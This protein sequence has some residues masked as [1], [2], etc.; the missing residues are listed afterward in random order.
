M[1]GLEQQNIKFSIEHL[2]SLISGAYHSIRRKKVVS[3]SLIFIA[4]FSLFF[5][6]QILFETFFYLPGYFKIGY[7]FVAVIT[8]LAVTSIISRKVSTSTFKQFYNHF[9]QFTDNESVRNVLDLY[10]FKSDKT[11]FDHLAIDQNLRNLSPQNIESSLKDF[12]RN[13]TVQKIFNYAL[14]GILFNFFLISGFT[15]WNNNAVQRSTH[16]WKSYAKPNP[17]HYHLSPEDS[18][19]EQG[20]DFISTITFSGQKVPHQVLLAVKTSREKAFRKQKMQSITDS[21][22]VSDALIPVSNIEYYVLM[23]GYRTPVHHI[24]VQLKP[25]FESLT[26]QVSPPSYTKLDSSVYHYPFSQMNAYPG[27]IITITGITNKPVKGLFI[28]HSLKNETSHPNFFHENTRDS[29]HTSFI[30]GVTDTISFTLTDKF[31]LHNDNPFS[32]ILKSQKDQLPSVQI[33]KP[34]PEIS[35]LN[36]DSVSIN[37]ELSDDFGFHSVAL[38]YELSKA[39]VKKKTKGRLRLPV[40]NSLKADETY[41]WNLNKLNLKPLDQLTYWIEVR[42]ND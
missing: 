12:Q 35:V 6:I 21:S 38:Y 18:V 13:H 17:F 31:K 28:H 8:S 11:S 3:L 16:F 33:L 27:S 9:S 29:I 2:N 40:P 1:P 37:Y 7:T 14:S 19:I 4:A 30:S 25:R 10:L 5:I 22:F 39:Y 23:D 24:S 36:P 15:Y 20:S 42:D 26:V 34:D 41:N 32:F